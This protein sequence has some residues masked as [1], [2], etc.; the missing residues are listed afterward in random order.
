MVKGSIIPPTPA[1]T[2]NISVSVMEGTNPVSNVDVVLEDTDGNQFTGKTGS[3]GGCTISNVPEG[4]YSVM[5]SKTG[6]A[7]YTGNITVSEEN[8]TLAITLTKE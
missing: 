4:S 6:Y 5:A 1:V 3:A 2:R 7:V 8:T